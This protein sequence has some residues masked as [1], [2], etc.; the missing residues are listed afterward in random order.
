M[1]LIFHIFFMNSY[2][3]HFIKSLN[4]CYWASSSAGLSKPQPGLI[5]L[6][7]LE[8]IHQGGTQEGK[9]KKKKVQWCVTGASISSCLELQRSFYP[10]P[11]HLVTRQVSLSILTLY[12]WAAIVEKGKLTNNREKRNY[13]YRH[14]RSR[15][16][17]QA[18]AAVLHRSGIV[19][20]H[21][22][23]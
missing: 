14:M 15:I 2:P 11:W 13:N 12:Q 16:W 8:D 18:M 1:I 9:K 10:F 3:H 6:V 23:F 21:D 5:K 7:L 20:C 22:L 4:V 19:Q 17:A